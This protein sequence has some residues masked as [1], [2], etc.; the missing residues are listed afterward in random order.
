[1]DKAAARRIL[2][3]EE[4]QEIRRAVERTVD[5]GLAR[6]GVTLPALEHERLVA[7]GIGRVLR[8]AR[9]VVSESREDA[10]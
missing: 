9:A 2:A 3:G 8:E 5:K 7:K 10:M 6:R 4:D 1:M